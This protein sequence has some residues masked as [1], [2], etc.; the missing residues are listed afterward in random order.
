[1]FNYRLFL[2]LINFKTLLQPIIHPGTA[3]LILDGKNRQVIK[4]LVK[5]DVN[6]IRAVGGLPLKVNCY[7]VNGTD[8]GSCVFPDLCA[9]IKTIFKIDETNC[10][11][12]LIDNDILCTCPFNLP[13]RDVNINQSFDLPNLSTFSSIFHVEHPL[14]I[15][16]SLFVT[17]DFDV[18]MKAMIGT[19]NILCLN[20][21]FTT[22]P[23]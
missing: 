15:F 8:V 18:T 5:T 2:F 22:K 12:N 1:L 23:I 20:M 19:T 17:G 10:P 16:P 11:Q 6:I 3:K 4:G 13:I 7:R 14:Q 9:Y 21:K